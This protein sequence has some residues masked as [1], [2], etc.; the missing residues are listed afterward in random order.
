MA[1]KSC[2]E[3]GR[4]VYNGT[5]CGP[6]RKA[7]EEGA[8]HMEKAKAVTAKTIPQEDNQAPP[9][10]AKPGKKDKR[11]IGPCCSCGKTA[12]I[13]GQGL[14]NHCYYEQV[15]KPN[16]AAK[17]AGTELPRT[18]LTTKAEVHPKL[19]AAWGTLFEE[20]CIPP[21]K[22]PSDQSD[23]IPTGENIAAID[24]MV[25]EF[26]SDV[27]RRILE[28][29]EDEAK[30]TRRSPDQQ[31]LWML[32]SHL[33]ESRAAIFCKAHGDHNETNPGPL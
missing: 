33:P 4:P 25:L 23:I 27:D 22:S 15:E 11:K 30:R 1:R 24:V 13:K 5:T 3:C 18:A 21:V 2:K 19:P 10:P 32:Q 14:C 17:K 8:K 16:M 28:F 20:A 26:E 12:P 7:A 29:I 31:A 9:A 6:C